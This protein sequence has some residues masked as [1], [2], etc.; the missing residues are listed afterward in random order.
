[1]LDGEWRLTPYCGEGNVGV[2]SAPEL[3]RVVE[4]KSCGYIQWDFGDHVYPITLRDRSSTDS[5]RVKAW[6]K[7]ARAG[8]LPPVLLYWIS[9]L[10]AHVVLDGHDRLLAALLEEVSAPALSLEL[11]TECHTD[12]SRKAAVLSQVAKALAAA[13]RERSRPQSERLARATRL[14]DEQRANVILLDAFVPKLHV[15][16]THSHILEGGFEQWTREV[17]QE[18][19]AQSLDPAYVLSYTT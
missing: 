17:Y 9:G 12:A 4:Q 18:C 16:P 8:S 14:I 1:M 5:G 2:I 7:H 10:A 6:R 15:A 19:T 13:D 11:V 3:R